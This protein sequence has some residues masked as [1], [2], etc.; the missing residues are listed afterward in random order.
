MSG[1]INAG[2]AQ[3]DLGARMRAARQLGGLRNVGDLADALK[4]TRGRLGTTTLRSIER[5]EARGD[6][7]TYRD[8]ADA[9]GIPVEFFTADFS[10]LAE[11]SEDPR[12]V[13]ARETAAA[14]RRVTE[15]RVRARKELMA[16]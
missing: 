1:P 15:R 12:S 9:C 11:I 3:F 14:R 10:R 7:S 13:I 4:D 6:F 16:E 5:G 2:D 8:I